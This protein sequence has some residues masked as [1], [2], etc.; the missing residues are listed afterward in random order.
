MS[1]FTTALLGSFSRIFFPSS[2]SATGPGIPNSQSDPNAARTLRRGRPALADA[3]A[4]PSS[5]ID[6]EGYWAWNGPGSGMILRRRTAQRDLGLK[7]IPNVKL[8]HASPVLAC[9]PPRARTPS[10]VDYGIPVDT[11]AP[12]PDASFDVPS[13]SSPVDCAAAPAD[14]TTSPASSFDV[15]RR[16]SPAT[17]PFP[18]YANGA[19]DLDADSS[20]DISLISDT[21]TSTSASEADEQE[22][23]ASDTSFTLPPHDAFALPPR[24]A[25]THPPLDALT[26]PRAP[27]AGMG[28]GLSGLFNADGSPFDGMGVLSFG[29]RCD[30]GP[31]ERRRRHDETEGGLSRT[32]LEEAARTWAADPHHRM[33]GVIPEI[34]LDEERKEGCEEE[35]Q[36]QPDAERSQQQPQGKSK[37]R[38][39]RDLSTASTI[40]SALKRTANVKTSAPSQARA[41]TPARAPSAAPG[42]RSSS[43]VPGTSRAWRA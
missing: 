25:F 18:A 13:G 28:L 16:P 40:S 6:G 5:A 24:D 27:P 38:R 4:R 35:Q 9:Q 22:D 15:A 23:P 41:K 33:M 12:S 21:S 3:R 34:G 29:L 17:E 43:V 11:A 19:L 39:P 1:N 2:A 42:L 32:F 20:F 31:L 30:A 26:L 10:P 8:A 14:G 36:P 37:P 7:G